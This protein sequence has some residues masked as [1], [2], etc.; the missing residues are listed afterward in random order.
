MHERSA[1]VTECHSVDMMELL[2]VTLLLTYE[3]DEAA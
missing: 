2:D 3:V 1:D